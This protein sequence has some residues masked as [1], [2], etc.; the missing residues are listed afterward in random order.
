MSRL[1]IVS[2]GIAGLAAA[3]LAVG[4]DTPQEG[5]FNN[6]LFTPTNCGYPVAGCDFEDSI[7]VGGKIDIHIEGIDGF[8]T[9]GID[10]ESANPDL[11]QVVAVGDTDGMPTW[12]LTALGAGVVELQAMLDGV[13]Q[14]FIEI[15]M[16]DVD[17]LTTANILGE[18]VGPT[19]A[20]ATDQAWTINADEAVSFQVTP[21]IGAGE[22][23]P[24]MGRFGYAATID[25]GLEDGALEN[26][27]PGDGYLY[28]SVPAG[29]Y[30]AV[31]T[32]LENP[33]LTLS[34][35]FHAAAAL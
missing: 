25:V 16:Q 12:E 15:P 17:S 5:A 14:D 13:E 18:A 26:Q 33:D 23:V 2:I 35:A 32:S 6:V 29:D 21:M 19:L 30:T 4:C 7:G 27:E 20:D 3:A 1:R 11:L 10:L 28:F 34:V 22:G 24:T 9:A 8:S 31:F